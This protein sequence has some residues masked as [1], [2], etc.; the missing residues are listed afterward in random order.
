MKRNIHYTVSKVNELPLLNKPMT[1]ILGIP[2]LVYMTVSF[3]T[4]RHGG[5]NVKRVRWL[6]AMNLLVCGVSCL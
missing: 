4:V 2:N 3:V 5:Q 6:H 1:T